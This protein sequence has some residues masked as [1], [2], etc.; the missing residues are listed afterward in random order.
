VL[1]QLVT[2]YRRIVSPDEGEQEEPL[3]RLFVK[4]FESCQE[5]MGPHAESG[6]GGLEADESFG[7]GVDDMPM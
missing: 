1:E 3:H 5:V 2:T 7:T 4:E 6:G